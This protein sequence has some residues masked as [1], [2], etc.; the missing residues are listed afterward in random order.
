MKLIEIVREPCVLCPKTN[1]VVR[2]SECQSCEHFY[3]YN[4]G[5][6]KIG[7][8][9]DDCHL[10]TPTVQRRAMSFL[11]RNTQFGSRR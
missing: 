5:E 2:V 6:T 11:C 8:R 3:G 7:C 10:G 4:I 9:E 1:G